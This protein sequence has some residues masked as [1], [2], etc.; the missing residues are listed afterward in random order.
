[1]EVVFKRVPGYSRVDIDEEDGLS[2]KCCLG[3]DNSAVT[4][5]DGDMPD[6]LLVNFIGSR[7]DSKDKQMACVQADFD[8]HIHDI[9]VALGV[10]SSVDKIVATV[11]NTV[12]I[13]TGEQVRCVGML[14]VA[15]Y[16]VE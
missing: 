11:Y 6:I 7:E 12:I 2:L 5:S 15:G 10:G 8:R 1:M 9:S 3:P 14:S 16:C 4:V 13:S